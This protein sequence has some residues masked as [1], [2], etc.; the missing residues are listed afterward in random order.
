MA[1]PKVARLDVIDKNKIFDLIVLGG[2]VTGANILWDASLRGLDAVLFEKND[3]ASGTTQ[4]TS[5]L[6]HGG[7]RY[8][9]NAEFGLVR[10]SLRER[11]YLAKISPHAIKPM[12]FMLPQYS[13]KNRIVFG[14]GL[15]M[16]DML[17]FDRNRDVADD[18]KIPGSRYLNREDTMAAEPNII[19]ENLHGSYLYYDYANLNPERHTSQF[20]FSAR[21]RGALG[22]NYTE[23]LSID[24]KGEIFEITVWDKVKS[25]KY[26]FRSKTLINCA[27]PW[28]DY[29]DTAALKQNPNPLIRSKGIHIVTRKIC[30]D[31]TIAVQTKEG[32]HLFIIPWRGKTI[33]GTTDVIYDGHPD[34]FK[35]TLKDITDLIAS[36]RNYTE[37]SV[38]L[39]DV[40]MFY[41]GLRPLVSD[42]K[43][44]KETYNA[45]RKTEITDHSASG[46]KG[47]YT[48]LGGKYTTSRDVAEKAVNKICSYLPGKFRACQ[49]MDIPVQGGYIAGIRD[50][51]LDIKKK[52]P[53]IS[54]E[55]AYVLSR[56]YGSL[57]EEILKLDRKSKEEIRLPFGVSEVYYPEEIE[58]ICSN[59]DVHFFSDLVFRRSGIG[60]SGQ[61]PEAEFK[62]LV[63]SA[64]KHFGGKVQERDIREVKSRY[65]LPV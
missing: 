33:I 41:G 56:R 64:A 14:V 39:E 48:A 21:T 54:E 19:K 52:Y 51:V 32:A 5:K 17:S 43:S 44:S 12:G 28:A 26:L 23:V 58:Y 62:K 13:F 18:W 50:A 31:N 2:G 20:I 60:N 3:Y 9:K 47:Y 6:I 1:V 46:F 45:S 63:L 10:E 7:L 24:K 42:G 30:G 35:V 34:E 16:Y 61:L 29:I 4:A 55:K 49:T 11:R 37:H 38:S 65:V 57:A 22:F 15:T 25:R 8:L 27:G 53:H 36:A 40:E 59:E